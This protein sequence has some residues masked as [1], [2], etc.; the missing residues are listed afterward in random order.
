MRGSAAAGSRRKVAEATGGLTAL[1]G[2]VVGFG[3][4]P[5][6]QIDVLSELGLPGSA[7]G[8][9]QVPGLHNGSKAF[10]FPGTAPRLW[11]TAPLP[12]VL[13]SIPPAP[14]PPPLPSVFLF[15]SSF[16]WE[17]LN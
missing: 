9:R 7:A 3:V 4:D 15:F 6:L 12:P 16:N 8:V 10:L 14:F 17:T 11:C 13:C 1:S 2:S 5:S